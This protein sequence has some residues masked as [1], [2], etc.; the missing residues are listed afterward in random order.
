MSFDFAALER[1]VAALESSQTASL[2]FAHV[3]RQVWDVARRARETVLAGHDQ[4]KIVPRM[5][6]RIM[7]EYERRGRP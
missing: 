4:A 1:R 2:R 7:S 3:R 5:L 6:N